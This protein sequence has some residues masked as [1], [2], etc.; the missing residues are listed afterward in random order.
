MKIRLREQETNKSTFCNLDTE[1]SKE[2]I[3]DRE[4]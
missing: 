4:P 1:L 2:W 3:I